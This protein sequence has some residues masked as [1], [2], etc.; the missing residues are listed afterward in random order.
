MKR[1]CTGLYQT[2]CSGHI[3][4]V[5]NVSEFISGTLVW[6]IISGTLDLELNTEQLDTMYSTKKE[7]TGVL[8]EIVKT[9]P[10][11]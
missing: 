8:P 5:R 9:S 7:C 10:L 3:I 4:E 11:I 1:I 6:E 2:E